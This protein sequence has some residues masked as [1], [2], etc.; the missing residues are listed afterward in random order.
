MLLLVQRQCL[1]IFLVELEHTVT[2]V[3]QREFARKWQTTS[4]GVMAS[5]HQLM[6]VFETLHCDVTQLQ[7]VGSAPMSLHLLSAAV[8]P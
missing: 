7:M 8:L 5:R 6:C 2:R 4:E 3:A 1:P